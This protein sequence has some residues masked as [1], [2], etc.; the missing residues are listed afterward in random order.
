[1][2]TQQ[3]KVNVAI[4][5]SLSKLSRVE[6]Q[7]LQVAAVKAATPGANDIKTACALV[8][9]TVK[10]LQDIKA[11]VDLNQ[12]QTEHQKVDDKRRKQLEENAE[13]NRKFVM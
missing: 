6:Q 13:P 7:L 3:V 9:A 8:E 11:G 4:D 1:M 5:D 10:A 12:Q 2:S